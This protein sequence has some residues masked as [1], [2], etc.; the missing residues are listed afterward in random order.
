MAGN[1]LDMII[2]DADDHSRAHREKFRSLGIVILGD[3]IIDKIVANR[4]EL[5][6]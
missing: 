3:E 1:Q 4:W 6:R 2:E 5:D